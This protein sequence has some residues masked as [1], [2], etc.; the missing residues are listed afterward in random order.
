MRW[1]FLAILCG[2]STP[3]TKEPVY[4]IGLFGVGDKF[5]VEQQIE[6]YYLQSP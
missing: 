6:Y 1:F 3:K 5:G 2:C 4:R